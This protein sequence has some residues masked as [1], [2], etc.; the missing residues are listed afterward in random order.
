[1]L[2]LNLGCLGHVQENNLEFSSNAAS[3]RQVTF[4][5]DVTDIRRLK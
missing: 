2:F 3:I 1:M 5:K 4:S